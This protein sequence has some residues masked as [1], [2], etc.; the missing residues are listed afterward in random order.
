MATPKGLDVPFRMFKSGCS[1]NVVEGDTVLDRSI[2]TIINTM[3]GERPY[4]PD[5]GSWVRALVFA[6]MTEAAAIQAGTEIRRALSQ[7]EPRVS[8]TEVLFELQDTTIAITVNWRANGQSLDSTT[9]IQF[10]T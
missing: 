2:R 6:N 1:P 4:R 9:T 3:P 7:W 5:F 8:V 10:R